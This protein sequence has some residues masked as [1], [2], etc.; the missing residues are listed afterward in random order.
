MTKT[1]ADGVYGTPPVEIVDVARGAIQFSPLM[2]GAARLDEYDGRL[3]SIVML[4]PPGTIERRH[5]MARALLAL[6]A[7]GAFTVLAPRDKGGSRLVKELEA[8]GCA[9]QEAPKRHFRICWTER[10]ADPVRL[11][12]A[13]ADGAPRL[14]AELGLWSQPGVF[15]WNRIDPGSALLTR[16]LPALSGRGADLGAGIGYLAHTVLA[17]PAVSELTLVDIDRRAID[18]ARRNVDDSRARFA[19]ADVRKADTLPSGLDF[20]VMNPPFHD[21][22]AE[23][24]TLGQAFI[25]RAS[26]SLAKGGTLWLTA[27][28][29]LP[30]EEGLRTLF[31]HVALVVDEGGY[32]VYEAR[33]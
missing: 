33:K 17:S 18:V 2:P 25:R 10:P 11:A 27:N 24:R 29:H 32:K 4:A 13:I 23:D 15:S 28:R 20:I 30:Y 19:W 31:K 7:G 12:D 21:G 22:G 5:E 6:R 26:E 9:V 8:F 1:G 16:V 3:D 14:V